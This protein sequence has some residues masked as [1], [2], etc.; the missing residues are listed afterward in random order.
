M[1][2][3]YV[4]DL[5]PLYLESLVSEETKND[6]EQHLKD[7]PI[8][9]KKLLAQPPVIKN[10]EDLTD[11]EST[12]IQKKAVKRYK[13]KFYGIIASAVALTL[14]VVCV[15]LFGYNYYEQNPHKE[16]S[17]SVPSKFNNINFKSLGNKIISKTGLTTDEVKT[18]NNGVI[19]Q[20]KPDGT[21]KNIDNHFETHNGQASN[22]Y[23]S[24]LSKSNPVT[25]NLQ[26]YKY[27]PAAVFTGEPRNLSDILFAFSKLSLSHIQE[28]IG[29]KNYKWLDIVFTDDP[30]PYINAITSISTFSKSDF[31]YI[32]T[33][34]AP[35]KWYI[36]N[37][38]GTINQFSKQTKFD[39]NNY[40]ILFVT[41]NITGKDY[42]HVMDADS[43]AVVSYVSGAQLAYVIEL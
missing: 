6:I 28:N 3:A 30:L 18:V 7:C 37:K 14:I 11:S 36:I 1:K 23:Y 16:F 40:A 39:M 31:S 21:V 41:P 33:P 22:F 12:E 42:K 29:T 43:N 8:C 5:F 38:D 26:I 20:V 15:G 27:P 35:L 9:Q 19:L 4:E 32:I 17:I 13:H 24:I 25:S 10:P 34:E 2:C